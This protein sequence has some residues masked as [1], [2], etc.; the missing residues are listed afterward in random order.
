MRPALF[1]FAFEPVKKPS[2]IRQR[3]RS[4]ARCQKN[5]NVLPRPGSL[6]CRE[7]CLRL[8]KLTQETV[9][10]NVDFVRP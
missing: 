5:A 9:L 3:L 6:V 1:A 2:M 7:I 8:L 10:E 4:G